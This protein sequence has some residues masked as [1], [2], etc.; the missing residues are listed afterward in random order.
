MLL[1]KCDRADIVEVT[2]EREEASTLLVVP[3]LRSG[4]LSDTREA[5]ALV[6]SAHL[7]LVVV[8]ARHEERL[9]GVEG[10]ASN[11]T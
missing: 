3:D 4:S 8:A 6:Q 10:N 2:M 9:A 7:D 1:V 5:E 11:R